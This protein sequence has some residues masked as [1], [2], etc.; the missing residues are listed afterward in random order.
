[1][2]RFHFVAA[3][4]C[5]A[6]L[7]VGGQSA[8]AGYF[9]DAAPASDTQP[10]GGTFDSSP[11]MGETTFTDPMNLAGR[12]RVRVTSESGNLVLSPW[13]LAKGDL[14][15][16]HAAATNPNYLVEFGI[17]GSWYKDTTFNF[18]GF[19]G[20]ETGL[21]WREAYVG[22]SG[23]HNVWN[24]DAVLQ[25]GLYDSIYWKEQGQVE[26]GNTLFLYRSLLTY[27]L[28]SVEY[29]NL[30]GGVAGY[31]G[32][33]QGDQPL[34]AGL[35]IHGIANS[36]PYMADADGDLAA[37]GAHHIGAAGRVD[38]MPYGDR[39]ETHD[40]TGRL[41]SDNTLDVGGGV[42]YDRVSGDLF[43]INVDGQYTAPRRWTVFGTVTLNHSDFSGS[44]TD[45][46][47]L[48][49]GGYFVLPD[50]EAIVRYDFSAVSH[51]TAL[52]GTSDFQEISLGVNWYPN[53]PKW[54]D[55]VKLTA[56]L[57][58]L[59]DGSPVIQDLN[60]TDITPGASRVFLQV[61]AQISF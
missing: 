51:T 1:M 17:Q 13:L 36:Q 49:Q 60:Y 2:C 55:H 48:A 22:Y 59:P 24:Q 61:G 50:V 20:Y 18:A 52:H 56:A 27:T 16:W 40:L 10:V 23:L 58:W 53:P 44:H 39:V 35:S 11:T 42:A 47:F 34:L 15:E 3:A 5:A 7:W 4:C 21:T 41:G 38:W 12:D 6:G 9:D 54:S 19:A 14:T 37:A 33:P 25:A 8:F 31:W 30:V 32:N 46:G 26:D 29:G 28:G 45:W 57:N 43:R